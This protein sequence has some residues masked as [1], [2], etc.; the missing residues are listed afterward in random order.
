VAETEKKVK[1]FSLIEP[2]AS[3]V[4]WGFKRVETRSWGTPFRGS[5]A[6]HASK[7]KEVVKDLMQV[8]TLFREAGIEMPVWWPKRPEDNPLGKVVAICCL[9]DCRIMT[10]ELI[11]D[12]TPQERAFGAW[13]PG[14]FAWF[15]DGVRR[16]TDA[17]P[18]RGALGLWELPDDVEAIA[19]ARSA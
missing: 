10:P 5:I 4:A 17:I 7:S 18:C 11:A 19:V 6:I 16:I 9:K 1:G 2:W 12:Q 8:E 13:E 3:L 15:L 14:R